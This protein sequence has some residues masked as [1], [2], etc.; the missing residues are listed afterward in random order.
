MKAVL[1]I[2]GGF[3]LSLGMFIGGA[4]LAISF[5]TAKPASEPAVGQR[6]TASWSDEPRPVKAGAPGFDRISAA[7]AGSDGSTATGG[8]APQ[9]VRP[10]VPPAQLPTS[11]AVSQPSASVPPD[12]TTTASIH[13]GSDETGARPA[14]PAGLAA[15]HAEWCANRY[16]S[17]DPSDNSYRPYSGGRRTC[18][19]PYS[20]AVAGE[21]GSSAPGGNAYAQEAADAMPATDYVPADATAAGGDVLSEHA[22]SCLARYHSYRPEDNTYQPYDG[23]PRRQCR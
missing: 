13:P 1:A 16:R 4:G 10:G 21:A 15:A 18:V 14:P 3:A 23:G 2:L 6:K 11:Q 17:Y 19:S 7:P 5:L 9:A 20:N 22:R 8:D 12:R